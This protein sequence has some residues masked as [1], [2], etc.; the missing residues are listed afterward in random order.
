[1][2][3][4]AHLHKT[5]N[6]KSIFQLR[7]AISQKSISFWCWEKELA[8]QIKSTAFD[9]TFFPESF[10]KYLLKNISSS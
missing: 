9:S 3:V 5:L 10:P 7:Y 6:F 1:M 8:F 2:M 4:I